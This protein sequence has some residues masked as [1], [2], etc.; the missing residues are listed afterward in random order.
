[1]AVYKRKRKVKLTNGRTAV[2]QSSKW[3]VKYRDA[4]GIVRCVPAFTDKLASQQLEA[5]LVKEAEL[6]KAGIVDRYKE[7]RRRPLSEHLEDFRE[8]LL[9][10]G[11]TLKHASLIVYRVRAVIAGCGFTTWNDLQPSKVQ[12][13]L[14]GLRNNGEGISAQ[15]FN[16][17][18]QAVKQFSRWMVQDQRAS[19]SPL[20]HLKGLNVRTDRR[21]D[22]RALEPDQIRRLLEATATAPKRFGM[23]GYERYLL[24][25]FA[26]ETGLR[27]NEIRHLKVTDFDFDNL[28]VSCQAGYSKRRREDVQPL[29]SD[30]AVLLKE[31][32]RGKMPNVK[33]FGGTCGQL[34]KRTSDMIKADLA[35]AGIAYCDDSGRYVDFHSLRHT[36]GTLLA[37]AGVHPKVAQ[38]IM[39]HSDINLTMSRYTHTL[40][41]QE[42]KAVAGLPDLSLPTREKQVATGTDDKPIEAIQ[43]GSK[44]WTPKLTPELTPTAFSEC[45]RPATVGN[46]AKNPPETG[47]G[48]NCLAEAKLRNEKDS[49]SPCDTNN[50]EGGIRTRAAG[51]SPLDG[52]ANRCLQPL[53]H[54]SGQLAR[55]LLLPS[56]HCKKITATPPFF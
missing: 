55:N 48:S 50:G 45:T 42:A 4:D 6:A 23:S 38:S 56:P 28:T 5:K 2:R 37:A 18:L 9:A 15:T 17:Y 34:T 32:F 7:H 24:Y 3:Y 29:R 47:K 21:H 14:A 16:F 52:L 35:D 44:K 20:E 27:A 8:S 10:K 49:L 36:T 1:M 13:Y 40:A 26:A 19:E 12:R 33:A 39:R 22:R 43:T 51:L 54:L 53:G 46:Q 25:R 41:G 30:A 11:N 31:F